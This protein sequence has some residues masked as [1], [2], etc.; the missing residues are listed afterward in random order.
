MSLVSLCN[1]RFLHVKA[2]SVM[3]RE[4]FLLEGNSSRNLPWGRGSQ[5]EG[6]DALCD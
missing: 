1:V 4:S 6:R 2:D 3:F 5:A